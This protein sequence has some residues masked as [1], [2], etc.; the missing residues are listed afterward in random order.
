M[1]GHPLCRVVEGAASEGLDLARL[2]EDAAERGE[3]VTTVRTHYTKRSR[4]FCNHMRI[5]LEPDEQGPPHAR[6]VRITTERAVVPQAGAK[7]T[8][9]PPWQILP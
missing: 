1:I 6:H 2:V 5:A 8:S 4:A 9:C 3:A 7:V